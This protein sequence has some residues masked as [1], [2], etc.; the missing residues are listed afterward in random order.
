MAKVNN[1]GE[2]ELQTERIE[3]IEETQPRSRKRIIE[4][5]T[6]MFE[7][8]NYDDIK[9]EKEAETCQNSDSNSTKSAKSAKSAKI[10]DTVETHKKHS[11]NSHFEL[12][13]SAFDPS[14]N[15]KVRLYITTLQRAGLSEIKDFRDQVIMQN[16]THCILV[17]HD[18]I[19]NSARKNLKS[20]SSIDYLY[21][22]QSEIEDMMIKRDYDKRP[23][24][25][26]LEDVIAALKENG[27]ISQALY[28]KKV[29]LHVPEFWLPRMQAIQS[30]FQNVKF[31]FELH[32]SMERRKKR[33]C[34]L[35]SIIF[36][37]LVNKCTTSTLKSKQDQFVPFLRRIKTEVERINIIVD[38]NPID[39]VVFTS[40]DDSTFQEKVFLDYDFLTNCPSIYFET[41]T[42]DELCYPV[43]RLKLQSSY[44]VVQDEEEFNEWAKIFGFTSKDQLH[45]KFKTD[46]IVRY[47]DWPV[48]T[49]VRTVRKV[50]TLDPFL[51]FCVVTEPKTYS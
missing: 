12:L 18:Q 13:L 11:V 15:E 10:D 43:A 22:K 49:I 32:Q 8:R 42:F 31:L 25:G 5:A 24:I 19:S 40:P 51:S 26:G 1:L 16:V 23:T 50:G 20:N 14:R 44:F 45:R 4:S 37:D 38:Q 21:R 27:A 7:D 39:C 35:I 3:F 6:C 48:G 47:Y 28:N 2:L 41:F 46:K 36:T 17:S 33:Q 9:N 30:P 29:R 34:L